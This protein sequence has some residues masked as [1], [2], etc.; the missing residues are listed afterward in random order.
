V[1]HPDRH[2]RP[3]IPAML[4]A[5]DS[6]ADPRLAPYAN[7]RDA[8]LHQRAD[9]LHPGGL[10]IGEGE[11]VVRR[12]L[13]SRY[14]THSVL[15]TPTRVKTMRDALGALPEHVPV[16]V[17][18]QG[19]MNGIVGFNIHRGVLALGARPAPVMLGVDDLP[20][21][22]RAARVLVVMEDLT[23]HDNVGS[24]FRNVAAL[25][26]AGQSAILLSPRCADPLYRK[27]LRVSVGHALTVPFARVGG[28]PGAI[29]GLRAA[30]WRVVAL[31]TRADAHDLDPASGPRP[32]KLCLVIGS[33]GPG[34]GERTL[35]AA[36]EIVRIPMA[37]GVDSLN[38]A[39]ACAVALAAM[40]RPVN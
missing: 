21:A 14:A 37:A 34:L 18:P 40:I 32:G 27:S 5:I 30:G 39:T 9:P 15:V 12:L 31:G 4:V 35:A 24:I 1:S 8:E 11:L 19:V 26:G 36:D 3:K 13:E 7:L 38:A 22:V 6:L 29:G 10:F 33:E 23:N 2:S 20:E 17:V 28:W 25:A 16:Y